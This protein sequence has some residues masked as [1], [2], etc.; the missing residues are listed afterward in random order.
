MWN[1]VKG[2]G[3]SYAEGYMKGGLESW[4]EEREGMRATFKCAI[5]VL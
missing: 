3:M 2:S 1:G 5:L 4:G